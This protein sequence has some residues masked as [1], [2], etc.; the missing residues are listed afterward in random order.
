MA[1]LRQL[2]RLL[3][4]PPSQPLLRS[5]PRPLHQSPLVLPRS[6]LRAFSISPS[7]L[8]QSFT[9]QSIQSFTPS[10]S[11]LLI[12]VREPSEYQEGHIPSAINIPVKSQPD[13]LLLPE[14]E[15]EDR[16]GFAKPKTDVET[17]F[18]CRSGVR[19]KAAAQIAEQAGY[20]KVGEYGGS[21]MDWVER[22]G[23]VER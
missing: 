17:V 23:K 18:Y 16:F 8:R 5:G 1:A 15:F 20:S 19:S 7:H 14:E 11:K 2:P 10:P 3:R 22:G 9:F 13:A 6:S 12:D 21:W 4:T